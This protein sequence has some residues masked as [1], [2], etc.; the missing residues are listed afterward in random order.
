MLETIEQ[1]AEVFD[2]GEALKSVG[3]DR[4]Y[5]T[6]VVGLTQAAWPTL[7]TDI[8]NGVSRGDLGAVET[9][10]RLAKAAALNVSAKRAYKCALQLYR[11][12][13]KRDLQAA[14]SAIAAL[15]QEVEM[16]RFRLAALVDDP[17][18]S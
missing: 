9:G 15:E 16:L 14:L 2:V 8:R 5:L 7:L 4:E 13:C 12:A 17:C 6:E 11:I 3:G 10:A 18:P 1:N